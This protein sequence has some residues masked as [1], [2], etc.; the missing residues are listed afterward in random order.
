MNSK[1]YI[2]QFWN[3]LR[4]YDYKG[5]YVNEFKCQFINLAMLD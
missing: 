4:K 2:V 5:V 1:I 3:S